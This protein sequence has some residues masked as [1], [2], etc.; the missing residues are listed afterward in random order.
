M[1]TISFKESEVRLIGKLLI[2][3]LQ[4]KTPSPDK[5]EMIKHIWKKM[6]KAMKQNKHSPIFSGVLGKVIR[7]L[8]KSFATATVEKVSDKLEDTF[9]GNQKNVKK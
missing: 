8:I 2:R 3:E 6:S 5:I 9:K 1:T 4:R 7:N